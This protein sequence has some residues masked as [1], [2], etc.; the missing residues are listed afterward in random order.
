MCRRK[1][2]HKHD[3]ASDQSEAMS[4][5]DDEINRFFDK[6]ALATSSLASITKKVV[7]TTYDYAN[8]DFS[9]WKHPS[10]REIDDTVDSYVNRPYQT[11]SG[12]GGGGELD[13]ER[14][15]SMPFRV[16]FDLFNV[17]GS[18]GGRTPYGIYSHKGPSTREYN[19]C[20]RKDGTSVWDSEGYWRCLFPNSEV[21]VRLLEYKKNHLA[22]QILTKE[23]FEDAQQGY[24]P[25]DDGVIDLG[26]KGVFF[27]QFNEYLKWKNTMYENVRKQR[28]VSR[29]RMREAM[30][31][32]LLEKPLGEPSPGVISTSVQSSMDSNYDTNE[33]VL[34]ETKTEV[35]SDGTSTTKH[36]TKT[37]PFGGREWTIVNEELRSDDTK[38]GWF[39]NSK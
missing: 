32:G 37:K 12:G 22:G 6:V 10:I 13:P 14:P 19:D 21:P 17:F 3:A 2:D 11:R 16:P 35:F 15:F 36:V 39:W 28:E 23:D 30:Y 7:G 8:T 5:Y 26:P 34:R 24:P 25:N 9:Q 31:S 18:T 33:V 4:P 20:L 27:K 38:N 1:W 29:K